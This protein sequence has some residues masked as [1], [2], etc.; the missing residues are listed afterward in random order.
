MG[1]A[2]FKSVGVLVEAYDEGSWVG[3]GMRHVDP[4]LGSSYQ[5]ASFWEHPSWRRAFGE[6]AFPSAVL[7]AWGVL[8]P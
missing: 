1:S 3:I 2:R 4:G 6:I 7:G 5:K 8:F